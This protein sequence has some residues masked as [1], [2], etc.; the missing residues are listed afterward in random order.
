MPSFAKTTA[1]AD[2]VS[3]ALLFLFSVFVIF[4]ARTLPYWTA[5]APGPGFVPL[6]LGVLLAC[7]SVGMFANTL[8][9]QPSDDKPWLPD[10]A[11]TFRVAVVVAFTAAAAALALVVGLVVA[12]SV[13][14]GVTLAY[15]R[16]GHVRANLAA[17]LL[18]PI[19]IWLLFVRWLG[20][21]LPAGPFGF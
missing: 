14:M 13:F 2:R 21:P 12:S 18:T 17:V 5:N 20:V 7:A 19:V 10:R 3:A 4:E 9:V 11:T 6:W 15:L 1:Q 16:P 8:A